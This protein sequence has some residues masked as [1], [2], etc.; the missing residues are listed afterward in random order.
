MSPYTTPRASSVRAAVD[1]RCCSG[2]G[3]LVLIH[4]AP[5]GNERAGILLPHC[6]KINRPSADKLYPLKTYTCM[7]MFFGAQQTTLFFRRERYLQQF[8]Y[9]APAHGERSGAR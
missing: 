6:T 3:P 1:D 9:I 4:F 8:G 2:S 7:F 5:C